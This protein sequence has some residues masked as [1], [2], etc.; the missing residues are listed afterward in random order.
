MKID[1]KSRD[2]KI[3]KLFLRNINLSKH[4]T[5]KNKKQNKK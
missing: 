2:G 3:E 4:E 5:L 1:A